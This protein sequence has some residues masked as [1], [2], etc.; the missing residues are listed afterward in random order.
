VC[1]RGHD[2]GLPNLTTYLKTYRLGDIVDIK[3]NS[4]VQAG[5]PHKFYHGKTGRV[6][7][8]A[9]RAVGIIVNKRV[10]TRIVPKRIHV[11]I[12]HVSHSK[13]RQDFINRVKKNETLKR[14]ARKN[15]REWLLSVHVLFCTKRC[16]A[17][18][19]CRDSAEGRV[20][21]PTEATVARILGVR[22]VC[23]CFL[24]V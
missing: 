1:D 15:K 24:L 13:C 7:N 10:N 12:E 3:A 18:L 20:E 23:A 21:T 22:C 19:Y 11:R 2:A 6:F 4:A 17:G 8:V 14:E 16:D 5:M 9:P